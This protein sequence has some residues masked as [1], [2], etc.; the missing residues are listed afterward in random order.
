MLGHLLKVWLC[1]ACNYT[2]PGSACLPHRLQRPKLLQLICSQ[3]ALLTYQ[4]ATLAANLDAMAASLGSTTEVAAGLIARCPSL[5]M[6]SPLTFD[7]KLQAL[8]TILQLQSV[9]Q[10]AAMVVRQPTL[11]SLSSQLLEAKLAQLGQ[12]LG[13]ASPEQACATA[14]SM[15]ALLTLGLGT[16]ERKLATLQAAVESCCTMY[17]ATS[18]LPAAWQAQLSAAKP[19]VKAALACFSEQR[20]A[21]LATLASVPTARLPAKSKLSLSCVLRMSDVRY[22]ELLSS[23]EQK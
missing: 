20:Y 9:D 7:Q 2:T 15:P 1:H 16:L 13:G 14:A 17:G 18:Q 6:L 4:P 23:L 5:V 10:A 12:A 22:E 19:N 3:P 21:R 11:L 8:R